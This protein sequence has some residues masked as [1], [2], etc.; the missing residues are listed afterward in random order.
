MHGPGGPGGSGGAGSPGSS[1]TGGHG[2]AGGHGAG[3][4]T[5]GHSGHTGGHS[6]GHTGH[7]GGPDSHSHGHHSHHGV[8]SQTTYLSSSSG[9]D[10]DTSIAHEGSSTTVQYSGGPGGEGAVIIGLV[11]GLVAFS[12]PLFMFASFAPTWFIVLAVGF[13]A[14][15]V[16]I[17]WQA[18]TSEDDS[19]DTA[20]PIE[21]L[22]AEYANGDIDE[23]ELEQRLDDLENPERYESTRVGNEVDD[24]ANA[25][26]E[27]L[28]ETITATIDPTTVESTQTRQ[29][30]TPDGRTS[31][32][33]ET[34]EQR[35]RRRF[36][37]GELSEHEFRRAL[38]VLRETEVDAS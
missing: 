38:E 29:A 36:A 33:R 12:Y 2:D 20:D 34:P 22:K 8:S 4:H 28:V 13:V 35:L 6:H 26:V 7:T 5:G 3:G 24:T 31:G 18:F 37:E 25:N 11:I 14:V 9:T 10:T 27:T 32:T 1:A 17:L 15:A 23:E 19:A 16:A 21:R 30:T